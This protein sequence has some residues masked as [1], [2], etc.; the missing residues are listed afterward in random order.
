MATKWF[1]KSWAFSI[2]ALMLVLL[3]A[4][5]CGEAAAPTSPPAAAQ[6]TEAPQA[7]AQATEAPQ[8]A[9]QP[10]A[11]PEAKAEPIG[12]AEVKVNPGKLTIM[13]G[14]LGNEQFDGA[15]RSGA[16]TSSRTA[17]N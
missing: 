2:T 9:T 5:A 12:Q 11:V 17:L 16:G 15:F 4:V 3:F 14:T 7:A 6:A 13:V 8:A 10:T 1:K